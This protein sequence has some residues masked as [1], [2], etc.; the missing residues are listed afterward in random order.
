M[1]DLPIAEELAHLRM[2]V[3]HLEVENARLRMLVRRLRP[4]R[5]SKVP[6]GLQALYDEVRGGPDAQR[7]PA[8]AGGPR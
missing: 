5:Y 8:E 7:P 3:T 2:V 4:T 1:S 6:A